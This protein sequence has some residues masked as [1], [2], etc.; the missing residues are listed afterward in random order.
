MMI[1]QLLT[2]NRQATLAPGPQTLIAG[3][4]QLGYYGRVPASQFVTGST[5][6]ALVSLTAGN[7]IAANDAV[8]W[9]K[10]AFKGKTLYTPMKA[11][12]NNV[13]YQNFAAAKIVND[14]TMITLKNKKF[15]V[16]LMRGSNTYPYTG[17]NNSYDPPEAYQSEYDQLMYRVCVDNPSRN[18]PTWATYTQTELGFNGVGPNNTGVGGQVLCMESSTPSNGG[19]GIVGRGDAGTNANSFMGMFCPP[20]GTADTNRGWRPVLE[21]V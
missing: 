20:V 18:A 8:D 15:I 21:L 19:S 17:A 1:E 10:F 9:F 5:L 4:L 16:R 2:I 7:V 6:A 13:S 3:D 11:L 14:N 12:R